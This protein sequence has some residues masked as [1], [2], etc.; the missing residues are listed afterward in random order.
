MQSLTTNATFKEQYDRVS[1]YYSGVSMRPR[2]KGRTDFL[3]PYAVQSDGG[4]TTESVDLAGLWTTP[5]VRPD[6]VAGDLDPDSGPLVIPVIPDGSILISVPAPLFV[7]Q[8]EVLGKTSPMRYRRY[9]E[10]QGDADPGLQVWS[11]EGIADIASRF[12][13]SEARVKELMETD[14]PM[15]AHLFPA[16]IAESGR[17]TRSIVF[18]QKWFRSSRTEIVPQFQWRPTFIYPAE[19]TRWREGRKLDE[20]LGDRVRIQKRWWFAEVEDGLP[21]FPAYAH[22]AVIE[23]LKSLNVSTEGAAL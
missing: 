14:A 1:T 11:V 15:W 17:V 18:P 23:L 21:T 13:M 8:G 19:A 22:S 7:L 9:D 2:A 3:N 6:L 12:R 20:A 16:I 10:F 5:F 4:I